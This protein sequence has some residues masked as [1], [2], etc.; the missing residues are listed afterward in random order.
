M[1]LIGLVGS[2]LAAVGLRD[3]RRAKA[4]PALGNPKLTY[5]AKGRDGE[6]VFSNDR[7]QFR[8]Y[9]EFGGGDALAL[10]HI[11]TEAQ[12]VG[13]TGLPLSLRDEVLRFIAGQVIADQTTSGNNNYKIEDS[14]ITIYG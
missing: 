2:A 3:R 4:A 6:V 9:Y 7:T 1:N 5:A 13:R 14:C 8:M 12:W 11:P 10:I